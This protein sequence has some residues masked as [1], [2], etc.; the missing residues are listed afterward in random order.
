MTRSIQ[1]LLAI[2][3]LT[4]FSACDKQPITEVIGC[5]PVQT[6]AAF[7]VVDRLSGENLFFSD[8]PKYQIEDIKVYKIR[9][10]THQN[11]LELTV[12]GKGDQR[13]FLLP[14][15]FSNPTDTMVFKI[16]NTPDDLLIYKYTRSENHCE[17]GKIEQLSFNSTTVVPEK[18]SL[19]FKK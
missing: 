1:C 5:D 3:T 10:K 9:D 6:N 7:R 14:F 12:I 2:A 15:D 4:F 8:N 18:G 17:A 19:I 13:S 11:P 16:A